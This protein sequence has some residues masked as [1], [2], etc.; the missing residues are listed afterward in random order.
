MSVFCG[1]GS[2][3]TEYIVGSKDN[4]GWYG[5]NDAYSVVVLRTL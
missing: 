2:R 4:C 1:K 5:G 3:S